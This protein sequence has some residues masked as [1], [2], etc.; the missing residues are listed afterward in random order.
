MEADLAQP[1][2]PPYRVN[3][4]MLSRTCKVVIGSDRHY[5]ECIRL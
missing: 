5:I 4:H 2:D 1:L 3:S